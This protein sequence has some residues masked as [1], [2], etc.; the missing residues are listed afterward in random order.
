MSQSSQVKRTRRRSGGPA[1]IFHPA[2]VCREPRSGIDAAH[3]SRGLMEVTNA[4]LQWLSRILLW[5]QFARQKHVHARARPRRGDGVSPRSAR[6]ARCV[7]TCG[8][9]MLSPLQGAF[10]D[11]GEGPPLR[12]G[13]TWQQKCLS[14]P[15]QGASRDSKPRPRL[16]CVKPTAE[17]PRERGS[18]TPCFAYGY[19]P[20]KG[21]P[22]PLAREAP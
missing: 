1:W 19:P 8:H 7:P 13:N 12:A 6:A 16:A 9:H 14:S 10:R 15:L 5:R 4:F 3:P 21:G 17:K 20:S 22:S 2:S 11:S 18:R